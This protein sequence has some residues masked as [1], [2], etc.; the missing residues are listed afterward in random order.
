MST[1]GA[2]GRTA[3]IHANLSLSLAPIHS[4]FTFMQ[5]VEEERRKGSKGLREARAAADGE[6]LKAKQAL[7]DAEQQR[8]EAVRQC[9]A[10]GHRSGVKLAQASRSLKA[11]KQEAAEACKQ[12][13]VSV[14]SVLLLCPAK[15]TAEMTAASAQLLCPANHACLDPCLGDCCQTAG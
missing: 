1:T 6:A 3:V 7:A 11:A 4:L 9:E 12:A 10:E 14:A 13:K 5:A 8:Q 15:V 2:S